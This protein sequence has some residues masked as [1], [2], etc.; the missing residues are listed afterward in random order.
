MSNLPL[1]DNIFSFFLNAVYL[2]SQST[3]HYTHFITQRYGILFSD[4]LTGCV[5]L[6]NKKASSKHH[7]RSEKVK[8]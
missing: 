3:I 8:T 7:Q 4:R 6:P 1:L 2:N 5:L